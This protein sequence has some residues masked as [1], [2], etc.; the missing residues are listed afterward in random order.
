M[1]AVSFVDLSTGSILGE[2]S[3]G[4]PRFWPQ[5]TSETVSTG[6]ALNSS[7]NAEKQL[8]SCTIVQII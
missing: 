6:E 8:I 5:V 2:R 1:L 7:G 4:H 3:A